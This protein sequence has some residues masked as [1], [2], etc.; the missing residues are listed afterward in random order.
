LH[1]FN[2][3]IFRSSKYEWNDKLPPNLLIKPKFNKNDE[4]ITKDT[5][6][7]VHQRVIDELV[8]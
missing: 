1:E 3:D 5:Y 4:K 6:E 7:I 8:A 2:D